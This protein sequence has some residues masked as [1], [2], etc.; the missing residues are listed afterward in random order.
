[1]I[2]NIEQLDKMIEEA[3]N[4]TK[5]LTTARNELKRSNDKSLLQDDK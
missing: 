1:M 5:N 4:I 2:Y 3:K